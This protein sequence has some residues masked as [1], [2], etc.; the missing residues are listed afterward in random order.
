MAGRIV[1]ILPK[2]FVTFT[3]I[4][5]TAN[6]STW[7][8]LARRQDIRNWR[9]VT[10]YVRLHPG[11]I[12]S[13]TP[14]A[15]GQRPSIQVYADGYTDEDPAV[16]ATIT[17]NTVSGFVAQPTGS[18]DLVLPLVGAANPASSL[19]IYSVPANAGGYIAV[20]VYARQPSAGTVNTG[21]LYI[22]I[23]MTGK[24]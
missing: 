7:V 23:D 14:T 4:P 1:R 24:E 20:A 2:T 6:N 10:L 3:N 16:F 9:E 21:D 15:W 22:S 8:W 13:N 12:I 17:G 11:S 19:S 18:A 5:L